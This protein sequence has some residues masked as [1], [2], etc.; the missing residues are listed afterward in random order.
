MGIPKNSPSPADHMVGWLPIATAP[1]DKTRV[2]IA[3]PTK[4]KDDWFVGEAYFDPDNYEGGDWWWAG[5][6]HGDYNAGPI[7]D[8]NHHAPEYWQPMPA[9]PALKIEAV[10]PGISSSCCSPSAC[11]K[12]DAVP[13]PSY[14]K[15]DGVA[16]SRSSPPADRADDSKKRRPEKMHLKGFRQA[17]DLAIE[18]IETVDANDRSLLANAL[19][20]IH[21]PTK[22]AK[23]RGPEAT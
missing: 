19:R 4:E 8:C 11:L 6:G 9:A 18:V 20:A 15:F 7:S 16:T 1:L 21:P 5:T 3:V 22:V 2:I 13:T 14:T 12:A 23:K 17:R 10:G